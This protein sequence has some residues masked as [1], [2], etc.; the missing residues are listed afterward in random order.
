MQ[1]INGSEVAPIAVEGTSAH[2]DDAKP[3]KAKRFLFGRRKKA[4][5]T[6][7]ASATETSENDT[8]D[9]DAPENAAPENAA[10]DD[11]AQGGN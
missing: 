11:D 10:P 7:D 9:D 2:K 8:P 3:H 1:T 5:A 4:E 6:V